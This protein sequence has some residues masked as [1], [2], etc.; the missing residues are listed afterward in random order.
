MK[1][2]ELTLLTLQFIYSVSLGLEYT[3]RANQMFQWQFY[4]RQNYRNNSRVLDIFEICKNHKL[5]EYAIIFV[6]VVTITNRPWYYSHAYASSPCFLPGNMRV[7]DTFVWNVYCAL[8]HKFPE[9]WTENVIA[10]EVWTK[11][12]V[13][14][15]YFAAEN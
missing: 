8:K 13:A 6:L 11:G 14:M 7:L 1:K 15:Q 3:N 4:I 10:S 2:R 9:T 5:N 12:F